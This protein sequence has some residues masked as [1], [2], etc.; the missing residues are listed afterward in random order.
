MKTP[1]LRTHTV[2]HAASSSSSR[3]VSQPGNIL[4]PA[5]RRVLRPVFVSSPAPRRAA[6]L[7]RLAA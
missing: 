6:A 5:R 4:A 7:L 2:N 3:A 1:T